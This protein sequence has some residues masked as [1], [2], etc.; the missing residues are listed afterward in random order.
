MLLRMRCAYRIKYI[1]Y[2]RMQEIICH[3]R[4]VFKEYLVDF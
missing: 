1:M 4:R 2:Y 3:L